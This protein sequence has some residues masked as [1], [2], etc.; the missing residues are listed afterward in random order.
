MS[1]KIMSRVWENS[2]QKGS[3]LL[4]LLALADFSAD[5]A[6]AWCGLKKLSEKTRLTKRQ[7]IN[8]IKALDTTRELYVAKNM[9]PHGTNLY[10]VT[11]G[12]TQDEFVNNLIRRLKLSAQEADTLASSVLSRGEKITPV[13]SSVKKVRQISPDPLSD[14]SLNTNTYANAKVA[15]AISRGQVTV[16]NTASHEDNED[17]DLL[18]QE[19]DEQLKRLAPISAVTMHTPLPSTPLSTPT[20]NEDKPISS[21]PAPASTIPT[22]SVRTESVV[23]ASTAK[24]WNVGEKATYLTRGGWGGGTDM[25]CVA[26]VLKVNKKR[27]TVIVFNTKQNAPQELSVDP[28]HLTARDTTS[29]FDEQIAAYIAEKTKPK[30]KLPATYG[31]L[32]VAY[33]EKVYHADGNSPKAIQKRVGQDAKLLLESFPDTNA[34]ELKDFVKEWTTRKPGADVPRGATLVGWFE[35]Y[36]KE[37][38]KNRPS[39]EQVVYTAVE[40]DMSVA[41]SEAL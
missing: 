20:G 3:P 15:D 7:T 40:I 10:F 19:L 34:D 27:I 38:K 9:G 23:N 37:W 22:K 12:I 2:K 25:R 16:I 26:Q 36:R 21:A 14:P 11:I 30:E 29:P 33:R 17:N 6:P 32:F 18:G 1:V 4:M 24:T 31:D 28:S 35:R 5:D 39:T 8:L 13:K 41:N